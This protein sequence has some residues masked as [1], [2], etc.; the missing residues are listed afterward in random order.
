[1]WL[2]RRTDKNS[3]ASSPVGFRLVYIVPPPALRIMT[4]Y[5]IMHGH[6]SPE[7]SVRNILMEYYDCSTLIAALECPPSIL[8]NS[9][10]PPA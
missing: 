6:V 10:I 7:P 8:R 5:R 1:M 2:V 9:V 4:E 3:T